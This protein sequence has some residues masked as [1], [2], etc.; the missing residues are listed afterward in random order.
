MNI[1]VVLVVLVLAYF[2]PV[3]ALKNSGPPADGV[4][5]EPYGGDSP[6]ELD[7]K[8][9]GAGSEA[10]LDIY[11]GSRYYGPLILAFAQ[12]CP[13]FGNGQPVFPDLTYFDVDGGSTIMT[14]VAGVGLAL[15]RRS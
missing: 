3:V 1:S 13:K 6:P 8:V 15:E 7:Y 14:T 9:R 10:T 5:S 4:A 12:L 2:P 11:H